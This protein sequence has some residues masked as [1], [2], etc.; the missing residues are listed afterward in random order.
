VLGAALTATA[1]LGA[2]QPAHAQTDQPA[3]PLADANREVASA[4]AAAETKSSEY[5]DAL[6]KAESLRVQMGEVDA[7]IAGLKAHRSKLRAIGRARAAI[8]YR[9][10]VAI[11]P[12]L[13]FDA[14]DALD[15]ARRTRLI[16][17][18]NA[19]DTT[20]FRQ[21]RKTAAELSRERSRLL[22][23]EHAEDGAAGRLESEARTLE[24]ALARAQQR[25]QELTV[26]HAAAL[27]AATTTT[28]TTSPPTTTPATTPPTTAPPTTTA[29]S[30]PVPP[31]PPTGYVPT[32]GTNPHHD[33][34][35][36]VCVRNHESSGNYQAYNPDGPYYG[37][38]QFLQATWDATANH[39]GRVELIGVHPTQASPYD[40]DDVAWAL[41]QW[42]GSA[43]WGGICDPPP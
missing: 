16:D 25:Q 2:G 30:T 41:Y 22:G 31:P 40:Q 9:R 24:A 39:M 33:D 8:A 17:G 19:A 7:R 14:R 11:S 27:A 12:A 35:F 29:P 18:L 1:F 34:P 26:A 20:V 10:S 13:F 43:P 15:I 6:E 3:D 21:L 5:L 28:T 36:L 4:R 42:R 37:A 23:L 38:Y 32:P